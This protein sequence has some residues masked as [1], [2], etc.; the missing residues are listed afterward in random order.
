MRRPTIGFALLSSVLLI[1]A[2]A[3]AGVKDVAREGARAARP[4]GLPAQLEEGPLFHLDTPAQDATVAGIVEVSGWIIDDRGV[5]NIDLFV[6]GVFA[7]TADLNIPRYDILQ[8]YPWYAGTVNARPGFSTSFSADTLTNGAHT[9]F[10]RVTFSDATTE[11]FGTR[12]VLVDTSLNQA[13]FGEL[14]LPGDNQPMNGVFPVT[15]WALDDG[16]LVDVEVMVDGAVVGLT[17]TGIARPDIHH[18]FPSVPGSDTA[19]F[20]RMVNTSTYTNGVHVV[21]V[22]LRD[23]QGATRVIGRRFVQIFNNG[24]NLAPFGRIEWPL[25]NHY[26]YASGCFTPGG[27]SGPNVQDPDQWELI[28]GWALD[29]GS[30]ID[31]GGVKWVRL[32][33]NGTILAD[34]LTGSELLGMPGY[35]PLFRMD[36]NYY[37]LERPDILGMFPD[38]PNAKDAGY[39]FAINPSHLILDKGYHQG[40]HYLKVEA[41]DIEGNIGIVQTIPVILDCNDDPDRPAW[42]DIYTPALMERVAGTTLVSGWAIDWDTVVLVEVLVDGDF[43]DYADFGLIATPEVCANFPWYPFNRCANAGYRYDMDT[44]Q[45]TDGPHKLVIRTV[46]HFGNKNYV[47]E[48]SFVVDNLN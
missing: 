22:R 14:E 21:A 37:G 7:A 6:D 25:P 24:K 17:Q 1:A 3:P 39:S 23:D 12:S 9:I 15:G 27:W 45:F 10:V 5:S 26:F 40:L 19:G 47:G 2:S 46:D 34:T 31:Q 43:I 44:T 30:S 42:G 33:L 38:V 4:A 41:G 8:A 11:D 18:R 13:P 35:F 20:V 48:R 29:V 16:S 32:M 28:Y 36:V